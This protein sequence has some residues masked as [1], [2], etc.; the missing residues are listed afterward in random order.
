MRFT[1]DSSPLNL[2]TNVRVFVHGRGCVVGKE[3]LHSFSYSLKRVCDFPTS[4]GYWWVARDIQKKTRKVEIRGSLLSSPETS[5]S[6]LS[7]S[8]WLG[9]ISPSKTNQV[10]WKHKY[11]DQENYAYRQIIKLLYREVWPKA[12]WLKQEAPTARH[13]GWRCLI[14]Q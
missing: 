3:L 7:F 9:R 1:G 10:F 14:C 5:A 4:L 2:Y 11:S 13:L 8:S 6:A 12:R